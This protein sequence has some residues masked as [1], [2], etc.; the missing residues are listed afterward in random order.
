MPRERGR[1]RQE[2]QLRKS[3]GH[4]SG[5]VFL[6]NDIPT[7]LGYLMPKPSLEKDGSGTF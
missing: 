5:L 4:V 3:D 2:E 1:E 7:F 6:F